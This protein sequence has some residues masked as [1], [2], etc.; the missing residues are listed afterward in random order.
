MVSAGYGRR[1]LQMN[2]GVLLIIG[3]FRLLQ[4]RV[5]IISSYLLFC[6]MLAD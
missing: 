6:A 3:I 5:L 4:V 1:E 2:N